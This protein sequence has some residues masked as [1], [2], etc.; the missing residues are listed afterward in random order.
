M[1]TY[2]FLNMRIL[3]GI[4]NLF[5]H[6]SKPKQKTVIVH[7]SFYEHR[8]RYL[9]FKYL[10]GSIILLSSMIHN[11]FYLFQSTL[12]LGRDYIK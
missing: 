1:Y 9:L 4:P 2:K 11:I 8:S 5:I 10:D 12:L 7:S 3:I 6:I